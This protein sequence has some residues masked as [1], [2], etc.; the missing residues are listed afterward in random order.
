MQTKKTKVTYF[1]GAGA[2]YPDL[3]LSGGSNSNTSYGLLHALEITAA[4]LEKLLLEKKVPVNNI[5][6]FEGYV[7]DFRELAAM[8]EP[9][10]NVELLAKIC[11]YRDAVKLFKIR[12]TLTAFF[13]L[14][15]LFFRKRH[16][17]YIN[18]F[19]VLQN[20]G[21]FPEH[22]KIISWNWDFQPELAAHVIR[23]EGFN[24]SGAFNRNCIP[25][26]TYYPGPGDRNTSPPDDFSM[27]H[28][29]GIAGVFANTNGK[30]NNPLIA[31]FRE[32]DDEAIINHIYAVTQSPDGLLTFGWEGKDN[33]VRYLDLAKKMIIDT[34]ILVVI[35]YSFP[36]LNR[37]TDKT[38]MDVIKANNKLKIY[39]QD[40]VRDGSPLRHRFNLNNAV[41]IRHIKEVEQFFIPDEL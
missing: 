31:D 8:A 24:S 14:E 22:V 35:G 3:P 18:F 21:Q 12:K 20:K 15:Q 29:N 27:I 38:L 28:V 33:S 1:L 37:A 36:F 26:V 34:H 41:E 11:S 13:L 5:E 39:Y 40:P 2:S 19:N 23:C 17:R 4:R 32:K 9:F 7:F 10:G 16:N 6:Y 30:Y 25:L